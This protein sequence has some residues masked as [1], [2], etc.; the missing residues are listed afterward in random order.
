MDNTI[1]LKNLQKRKLQVVKLND[2]KGCFPLVG[3]NTFFLFKRKFKIRE[4]KKPTLKKPRYFLTAFD[5]FEYVSS[6]FPTTEK[7][8]FSI[9]YEGRNYLVKLSDKS[10]VFF[11]DKTSQR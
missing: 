5:P 3:E 8:I 1:I 2:L 9:D 4:R 10:I 6:L 11:K 7:D